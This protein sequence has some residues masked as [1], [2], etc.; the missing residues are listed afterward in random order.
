MDG[1]NSL[2][3]KLTGRHAAEDLKTD[4]ERRGSSRNGIFDNVARSLGSP[5]P[6]RKA[7]QIAV[8]GIAGA[9]LVELG[10]ESAWA[11]STC[12]C[13]GQ[14]YDPVIECCTSFGVQAKHPITD[15][16]SC[17][18]KVDHPHVNQPNGCGPEGGWITPFV[19]DHPFGANFLVC[20]NT[21]DNCYGT[22][23]N[24]K[25]S[26]DNPFLTCLAAACLASPLSFIPSVLASCV[27][28][29]GTYFAA[30]HFGGDSAFTSAQKGACDCCGT[31]TCPQSCAGSSCG[32]LPAC[33]PG[34]DC[35]CFTSTEG[36]GACVHGNTPCAG[37][38]HCST[39]ADCP[40]G[41]AC[42]FTSCCGSFGVCGPLCNPIT[43]KPSAF[44]E[45]SVR[46]GVATLASASKIGKGKITIEK[47]AAPVLREKIA[48]VVGKRPIDE[49]W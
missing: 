24:A 47:Q 20:C 14:V 40:S 8:A 4:R 35:V 29:A 45:I 15:L 16:N 44:T 49:I 19:P 21:H 48:P 34:G 6:R 28:L 11:A 42:L 39:S 31:S 46:P 7:L 26:C 12:L 23:N 36:T 18:N 2:L 41:S 27:A 43:G 25:S 17:P 32:S 5:M 9:A 1:F 22:C 13:N 10:I 30:V 33:A 3:K 37:I 38:Q